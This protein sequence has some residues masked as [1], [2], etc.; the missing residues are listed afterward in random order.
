MKAETRSVWVAAAGCVLV[1]CG[2]QGGSLTPGG[3]PGPTMHTL[4]EIYQRLQTNEVRLAEMAQ[5]LEAAG[6]GTLPAGMTLIP[7]GSFMMGATTNVGHEANSEELPQHAV[8]VSAFYMDTCEVTKAQWDAVRTWAATNGYG[9]LP[10]GGGMA[11]NHPVQTVNWYDAVKWCNA[12]GEREGLAACYTVSGEVYRAG[13]VV[14]ACDFRARGYRLPTEAEWEKAAR[15]GAAN[16][17]FPWGDTSTIQHARANYFSS[18]TYTYDTSPTRGY[19]PIYGAGSLPY[20]SPA[21]SFAPNGYGLYGMAGNVSEWCWDWYLYPYYGSSPGTDPVGAESGT[22]HVLRGGSWYNYVLF[23]RV[24]ARSGYF[25]ATR[26]D[27]IGFRGVL[28]SGR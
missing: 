20:T 8:N 15:G 21:A 4:E 9:D 22:S 26:Y 12:R 25:P 2:V 6:L 7:S 5:R 3:S 11:A 23:C 24:A 27:Y 28:S 17:R 18:A 14:P 16:R 1:A 13:E 10:A 19:H